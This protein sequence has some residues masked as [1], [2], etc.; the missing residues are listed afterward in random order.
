MTTVAIAATESTGRFELLLRSG[1]G[2][3]PI[4]RFRTRRSA[5]RAARTV[6]ADREFLVEDTRARSLWIVV[7]GLPRGHV[8][9]AGRDEEAASRVLVPGTTF[10]KGKS[11][12][13][14]RLAAQQRAALAVARRASAIR[15]RHSPTTG[16]KT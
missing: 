15:G 7:V 2:W 4:G 12:A 13:A 3:T 14:A 11:F 5:A 16:E 10:G 9:Y 6:A 8:V 1:R